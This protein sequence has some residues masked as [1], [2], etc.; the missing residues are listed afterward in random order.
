M[1]SL[2]YAAVEKFNGTVLGPAYRSLGRKIYAFGSRLEGEHL[3]EDRL[4]PS[5]RKV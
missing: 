3:E 2:V 1:R 4:V 5:L